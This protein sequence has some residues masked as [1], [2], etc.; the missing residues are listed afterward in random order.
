MEPITTNRAG[1]V[2]MYW[3]Q[4]GLTLIEIMIAVAIIGILAAIAIPVYQGYVLEGRYGAANQEMPQ[5][6]V[7]LDD[8]AADRELANLD[9]NNTA[10]RGVYQDSDGLVVLGDTGTAP[11][12]ATAW[13]DPW[14]GIYRYQRPDASQQDYTLQSFGPDGADGGDD[15][16][17]TGPN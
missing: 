7:V 12:G 11:A 13:L 5:M 9:L 2:V 3:R 6:Q 1:Y 4:A 14:G 17:L 10:L 15:A 8:L 16:E